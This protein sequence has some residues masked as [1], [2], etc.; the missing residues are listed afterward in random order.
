[1]KEPTLATYKLFYNGKEPLHEFS[2]TQSKHARD[3][4]KCHAS[5]FD[6]YKDEHKKLCNTADG[7]KN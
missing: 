4:S 5:Y 6:T 1:M 2:D 7:K 3:V